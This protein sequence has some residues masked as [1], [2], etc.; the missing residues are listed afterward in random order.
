MKRIL[1]ASDLTQGSRNALNRASS[2]A[3]AAG[4]ELR[5]VHVNP[6]RE[7]GDASATAR[8][9]LR[10]SLN[11]IAGGRPGGE[12]ALSVRICRGDP[13]GVILDQATH[14]GADLIVLGA[15]GEPRL[16]DAIFGT[17]ASHVVR[18]ATAPV[19][20]A[21]NEAGRPYSR[22]LV[23]VDNEAADEVLDLALNFAS[24]AEFHIVHAFGSVAERLIGAPDLLGDVCTNQDVLIARARHRL[25]GSGGWVALEAIVEKGEEMDVIMRAWARIKP[26]LVVMGTHGRKGFAHFLHGSIAETALL[27]CPADLLIMRTGRAP[28]VA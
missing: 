28:L 25:A 6:E 9:W 23:A 19:L 26:D 13:A 2:I 27:G 7:A 16:R 3:A 8:V 17:T 4:A 21:Q 1:V 14:F 18:D 11:D 5:V 22:L 12:S 20:V 15:H 24:P 10:S